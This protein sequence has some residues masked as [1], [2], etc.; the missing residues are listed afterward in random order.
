MRWDKKKRVTIRLIRRC[1]AVRRFLVHWES[2]G[3]R[4]RRL[5]PGSAFHM[6]PAGA[7]APANESWV[8]LSEMFFMT[9]KLVSDTGKTCGAGPRVLA[10]PPPLPTSLRLPRGLAVSACRRALSEAAE[11]NAVPLSVGSQQGPRS[12][13]TPPSARCLAFVSVFALTL[14]ARALPHSARKALLVPFP[15]TKR[16]W[17]PRQEQHL[18]P[19]P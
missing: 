1:C 11:V 5:R 15:A 19:S 17:S 13:P 12:H 14:V 16:S 9:R 4:S 6:P 7:G 3:E 10:S 8:G 18:W 2:R